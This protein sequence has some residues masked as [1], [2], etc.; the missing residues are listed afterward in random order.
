M[1]RTVTEPG[2]GSLP[3]KVSERSGM[4]DVPGA[5]NF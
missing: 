1:R 4:N 3:K 5:L 2:R